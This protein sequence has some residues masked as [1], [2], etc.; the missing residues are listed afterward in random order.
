MCR[1]YAKTYFN[2]AVKLPQSKILIWKYVRLS[3]E[4]TIMTTAWE[5]KIFNLR[6]SI[7]F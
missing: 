6:N 5:I 2:D 7:Q 1:N 4:N 3:S